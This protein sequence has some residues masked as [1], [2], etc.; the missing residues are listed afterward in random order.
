MSSVYPM[1]A[2]FSVVRY[3]VKAMWSEEL[4]DKC[5]AIIDS[6]SGIRKCILM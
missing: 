1:A 2:G 3:V 4:S 5:V 6:M